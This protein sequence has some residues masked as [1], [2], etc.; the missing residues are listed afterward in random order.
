MGII[1]NPSFRDIS[2]NIK[3]M[4]IL[5]NLMRHDV[6]TML[7]EAKSGHPAGPLGLAEIFVVLFFREMHHDPKNPFD[8]Q[9]DRFVLSNGHVAPIYY[10]ALARC[11]YFPLEK[12]MTLRKLGSELQGHPSKDWMPYIENSSGPLGH[13]LSIACGIAYALRYD[14]SLSRVYCITSDGEHQE[15]STWEAAMLANKYKLDNL[16][17]IIDRN[18]IQIDGKTEDVMPL[19]PL[20]DKYK[21]FGWHTISING[22]DFNQ[23][24]NAL[25]EARKTKGKPTVIIANTVPGKG[26]KFMEHFYEWHG[27]PPKKEEAEKA[28]IE[29]EEELKLLYKEKDYYIP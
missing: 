1:P 13:G 29:L 22:H 4:K 28:L 18:Y 5:A 9:R 24:I 21:A 7:A 20:V 11:G 3:E 6:I 16:V 12:L 2:H 27:K 25:E 14:K 23:I 8:P 15:G 19:E 17:N 10:S 26:V